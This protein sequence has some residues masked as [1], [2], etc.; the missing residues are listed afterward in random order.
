MAESA[1]AAQ[2]RGAAERL[3]AAGFPANYGVA[4]YPARGSGGGEPPEWDNDTYVVHMSGKSAMTLAAIML[5]AVSRPG[6]ARGRS[7]AAPRG[8]PGVTDEVVRDILLLCGRDVPLAII[9]QWSDRERLAACEWGALE[10]LGASD[11]PVRTVKEPWFVKVA[12][13]PGATP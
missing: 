10:H 7:G 4:G 8:L 9:A 12:A 13:G 1:D 3:T 2:A 5:A 6:P 11:N